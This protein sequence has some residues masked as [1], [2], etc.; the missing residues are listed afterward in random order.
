LWQAIADWLAK[1]TVALPYDELLRD[2]LCAP[3]YGFASDG[4]LKVESKMEMRSRGIRSPD[5]AD[6][7]AL[8]FTASAI[9]AMASRDSRWRGALRRNIRGIV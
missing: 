4:R 6:S 8:T 9:L 7:L 1:R 2:D 3:R 5:S